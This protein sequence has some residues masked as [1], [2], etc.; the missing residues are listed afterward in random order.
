M[1]NA[2][3]SSNPESGGAGVESEECRKRDEAVAGLPSVGELGM[4]P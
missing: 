4:S 3:W 1:I 2:R